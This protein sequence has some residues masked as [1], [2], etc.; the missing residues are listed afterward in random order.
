MIVLDT[1]AW[2]WWINNPA[3]LSK[4]SR[5]LIQE[6]KR[7]NGIFISSIST[8]ELALLVKKDRLE[9]GIPVHQWLEYSESLPY[10]N[11]IPLDNEIALQAI[12]LP[13]FSHNDPADRMI[14]ATSMVKGYRL[15]T[16]DYR[17]RKYPYVQTVW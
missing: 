1:H 17:L 5:E 12:D 10:V 8:W 6:A 4:H 7:I 9:L 14:V 15:I 2:I 13:E 11:F 3:F 16:K